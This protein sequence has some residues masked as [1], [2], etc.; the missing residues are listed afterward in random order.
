M[1]TPPNR[2]ILNKLLSE[3][4]FGPNVATVSE[5]NITTANVTG[6]QTHTNA[7]GA[8]INGRNVVVKT[9]TADASAQLKSG[10]IYVPAGS[11]LRSVTVVVTTELV[12]SESMALGVRV[13]TATN[14]D[15]YIAGGLDDNGFVTAGT[16]N[17]AVGIGISSD[18][19]LSADLGG[20]AA[21]LLQSN[22]IGSGGTG[23][24]HVEL[25]PTA[26]TLTSGAVA[27][28]VEFDYVGGN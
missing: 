11:L 6:V 15:S 10:A 13:G 7:S 24:I 2:G 16:A 23:E 17:V 22:Y 8:Y 25:Q 26:G 20:A 12:R 28:I 4:S 14:N 5:A 19:V 1:A 18:T 27:F 9:A 3:L 21:L